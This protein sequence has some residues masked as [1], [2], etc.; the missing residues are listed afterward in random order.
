MNGSCNYGTTSTDTQGWYGK[1]KVWLKEERNCKPIF[2]PRAR[3]HWIHCFTHTK[4]T[5]E[6][7]TPEGKKIT[8]KGETGVCKGMLYIDLCENREE[9]C[10]IETARK[11]YF[12]LSVQKLQGLSYLALYNNTLDI[13]LMEGLNKL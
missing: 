12:G 4:K 3:S 11:I 1:L 13:H 8:L 5:W 6:A 9:I 10:M 7:I 2:H